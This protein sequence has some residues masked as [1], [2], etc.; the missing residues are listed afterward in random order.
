MVASRECEPSTKRSLATDSASGWS[1]DCEL[2]PPVLPSNPMAGGAA[3]CRQ[4]VMGFPEM[5]PQLV[6]PSPL[7][8]PVQTTSQLVSP[9]EDF[10]TEYGSPCWLSSPMRPATTLL[11]KPRP[12]Q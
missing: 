12:P 2:K 6:Y 11:P 8:L 1:P 5:P 3:S 9:D 4:T 7:A 10:M